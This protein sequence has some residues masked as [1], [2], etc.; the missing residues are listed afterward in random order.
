MKKQLRLIISLALLAFCATGANAEEFVWDFSV[1][2]YASAS[3]DQVTWTSDYATLVVDKAE[4]GTPAN[5][6]LG[7]SVNESTGKT[8]TS[9]RFYK[10]SLV[11]ITPE[12]NYTITSIVFECT[13]DNYAKAL[14]ES[15]W[16]N[17]TATISEK[18]VTITPTDGTKPFSAKMSGTVG[19]TKVTLNYVS[20]GG[21]TPPV[22]SPATGTYDEPQT[23][24]ITAAS[25][26]RILYSLDN[27]TYNYYY[28][29]FTVSET[30]TVYACS[31]DADGN[32]SS[33]VQST[34]TISAGT[35]EPIIYSAEFKNNQGGF[36][37]NNVN[38]PEGLTFV[39][40]NNNYGW[41]ASG[42]KNQ[43][44]EA[45]SWL[46]SPAFKI[47]AGSPATLSFSHALNKGTKDACGLYVSEDKTNWTEITVPNWPAGTDWNFISSGD[48]DLSSYAGK[49][50]YLGFKYASTTSNSP[51][52]EIQELTLKGKGSSDVTPEEV[53]EYTTIAAAKA[54]ATDEKVNAVLKLT[55]VTVAY[56]NGSSNYITD[57]TDGFLLYGSSLGLKTGDNIDITV[58]GQ[59]YLYHKLPELSVSKVD[60]TTVN[61][62]DNAVEP[63][64]VEIAELVTNPLKFSSMLVK[65][66][67]TGI[68]EE[69][70]AERLVTLIQ[71]GEECKMYDNWNVATDME[72]KTDKDYNITGIAALRDENVQIYPR[73]STDIELLTSQALPASKWMDGEEAVEAIE[74]TSLDDAVTAKFVTDSDGAVTY[75]SSDETVATVDESGNISI[76]KAGK[77]VITAKTAETDAFQA[78]SAQLSIKVLI[79]EGDGTKE[80]PYTMTDVNLLFDPDQASEPVW[81]TGY[82]VGCLNGAVS[83]PAWTADSENIVNSNF[84][85]SDKESTEDVA[86]CVPT[87]LPKGEIRDDFNIKDHPEYLGQKAKVYGVITKYFSVAGV[88]TVTEII[89]GE[90]QPE[91]LKGDVN[92]DEK[93]NISDVVAVINTMAGETTFKDTSDVNND[94]K[95]DIS[96]VVMI[97]NIMAGTE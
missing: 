37:P 45:E 71:D 62:S 81:V 47:N 35:E 50:I 73:T 82:I 63:I 14:Q 44:Y 56:V 67:G 33:S 16:D 21:V 55:N 6:Y 64:V 18:I 31:E 13:S 4:A 51:S 53:P 54:A 89:I 93:V 83:K 1:A 77:A 22:I 78:S 43:A 79:L 49:T 84:L 2:S 68:E 61:S 76:L 85:L 38:L 9:S 95:T 25:G 74:I 66:E 97:I 15:V 28:G 39:W 41:V 72:F 3:E 75:E 65:I 60:E 27:Q 92:G 8:I 58:T 12:G 20:A 48:I 90:D 40:T 5:N 52:W 23:V 10:N 24:T 19:S 11:T 26:L 17:A 87:E 70:W 91:P 42:Y 96:D 69:A 94:G 29:P 86:D 46:I 57:G 7:G 36:E 88:K 34:I 80:N 30:T 32:K 59:L